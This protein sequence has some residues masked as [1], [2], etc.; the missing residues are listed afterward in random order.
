[1]T[2]RA[3]WRRPLITGLGKSA[4]GRRLDRSGHQLTIDA[5]T[6][7]VADAGLEMSDIDGLATYPGL[8]VP[9]NPGFIGPDI[10]EIQDAL[11]LELNWHLGSYQGAAQ[12]VS[13]IEAAAAVSVGLCKH[14]VVFRT[15]TEAQAQGPGR[16]PGLGGQMVEAEGN[17]AWLLAS[18]AV[19]AANWA[20]M[21]AQRH[22]HTYGTSKEQLGWVAISHRE[23]ARRNPDAVFTDPLTMDDYLGSREISS[24]LS[25]YDCDVPVDGC[26][27]IVISAPETRPD[28]R[29]WVQIES[30]GSAMRHRPY[31]EHWPDLS[32]MAPHDAADH[33]WEGTDLKPSDVDVAQLYDGFSIFTLMWLEALKFCG[34]GESGAYAEGGARFS[35][36][37]SMPIN[38][39]GGQLSA[40]RLHGW[41]FLAEA[42]EQLWQRA[43]GRQVEGAEVAAVGIGGGVV[44]ASLLL[45]A[46]QSAPSQESA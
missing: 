17:L 19:S 2:R 32:T 16:R 45:T 22:M 15:T 40:G 24:P 41:G 1:M 23:H 38:T 31:W 13:L 7:A 12:F 37:S 35:L 9:L 25:L 27:A 46:G 20:G 26:V 8:T 33:M 3:Q 39:W 10:Y 18:G 11:G 30:V 4:V 5:I 42:L 6:T 21:Y 43:D 44:A 14:V 28:V 29:H 34:P 36:D